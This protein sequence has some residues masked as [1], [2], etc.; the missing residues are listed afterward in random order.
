[1]LLDL[2]ERAVGGDGHPVADGDLLGRFDWGEAS[3]GH[4][5]PRV[6]QRVGQREMRPAELFL[7]LVGQGSQCA[8]EVGLLCTMIRYFTGWSSK[9]LTA[10]FP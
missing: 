6:E 10:S 2:G 5:V 8:S 7:L 4:Q 9:S 1:M 3:R